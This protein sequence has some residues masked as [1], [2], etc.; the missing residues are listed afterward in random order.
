MRKMEKPEIEV[1]RFSN[2]DLIVTSGGG[3]NML[4]AVR[5]TPDRF[6]YSKVSEYVQCGGRPR[7]STDWF[8]FKLDS[9]GRINNEREGTEEYFLHDYLKYAW[10]NLGEGWWTYNQSYDDYGDTKPKGYD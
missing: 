7:F 1:F 5:L 10:Y 4:T 9:Q 3:E 8:A 2:D 6:Y